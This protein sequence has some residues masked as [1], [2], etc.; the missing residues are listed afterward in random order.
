VT[1]T[2]GL[3]VLTVTET[4]SA[5]AATAASEQSVALAT[6][7]KGVI[8]EETTEGD[9]VM[10]TVDSESSNRTHLH[11]FKTVDGTAYRCTGTIERAAYATQKDNILAMC[12]SMRK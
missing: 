12:S 11:A 1:Y 5:E 8:T 4:F 2:D 6:Q 9:L 10:I 7:G 3:G